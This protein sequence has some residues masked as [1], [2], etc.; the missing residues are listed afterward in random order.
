[1][2]RGLRRGA[3]KMLLG[4]VSG[5]FILIFV[6]VATPGINQALT[7]YTPLDDVVQEQAIRALLCQRL[8]RGFQ[9][10]HRFR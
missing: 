10:T 4:L 3:L 1:M 9:L 7:K 2:I 8:E 6:L 5:I